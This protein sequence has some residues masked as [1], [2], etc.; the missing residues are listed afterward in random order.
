MIRAVRWRRPRGASIVLVLGC[1]VLLIAAIWLGFR[2]VMLINGSNEVRNAVDAG[3]LNV[4]KRV[5]ELKIPVSG[6]YSD[7]ADNYHEVGLANIGRVW[8]KS[9]LINANQQDMMTNHTTGGYS[10][11][12]ADNAYQLAQNVNDILAMQLNDKANLD[13]FFNKLASTR[14]ANM[15]GR[16]DVKTGAENFYATALV[17]RGA[18]SNIDVVGGQIPNSVQVTLVQKGKKD[19]FVGY[20]PFP[21]NNKY[22]CLAALK[23]GEMPHLIDD[24]YFAMNRGDVNP[25]GTVRN[26][27]PNAFKESGGAESTQGSIGAVG[28]AVANPMKIYTV[29]IPHAYV[30]ISFNNN[31]IWLV[32]GKKVV[33]GFPYPP[34]PEKYW[35]VQKYPMPPPPGSSG[36]KLDGYAFLGEEYKS[37]NLWGSINSLPGDHSTAFKLLVQRIQEFCP[38]YNMSQLQGLLAATPIDASPAVTTYY[39]FPVYHTGD[40]TDPTVQSAN[41]EGSLP[42]WLQQN[43]P[44]GTGAVVTKEGPQEDSPNYD[45]EN[46]VGGIRNSGQHG[47]VCTGVG[48]WTPGT[49]YDQNLGNLNFSRLTI[50]NFSGQ[51]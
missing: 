28:C 9:F 7:C 12:N 39:I 2:Y 4:S 40:N 45:W 24:S 18:E 11:S 22:F 42:G 10:A 3:A 44:D 21:A 47:T 29:A 38:T 31:S 1:A 14:P 32:E 17:D 20:K 35:K 46:I 41:N 5:S 37:G 36:G 27:V 50:C 19:F 13:I 34:T 16:A 48:T 6:L 43:G 25:I 33:S 8:G 15:L 51:Q 30:T 26:P 23:Y 49:G